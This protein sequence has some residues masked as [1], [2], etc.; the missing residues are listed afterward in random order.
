MVTTKTVNGRR[1]TTQTFNRFGVKKKIV[2]YPDS[3][4]ELSML[5]N[6]YYMEILRMTRAEYMELENA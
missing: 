1:E 6:S 2:F 4:Q 3:G 5:A